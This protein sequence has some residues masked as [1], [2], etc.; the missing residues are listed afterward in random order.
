MFYYN[1]N[2]IMLR[3]AF[4]TLGC[5]SNLFDT[6]SMKTKFKEKGYKVVN[7][8]EEVADIYIVNTCTVTKSGDRSSRKA[9]YRLRRRNPKAIIVATG[10]YAQ[11]SPEELMNIEGVDIVVGNTHK[12]A[13]LNIVE[14][15]M[16]RR[17]KKVYVGNIFKVG[18]VEL[19]NPVVYFENSRPF[20]KVQ[21]GCNK[22]CTFCVIPF[23]RG[24]VRSVDKDKVVDTVKRLAY[25]GFEEVVLSGT[26]LSQYGW[27]KG[28]T[29]YELL[30]E[31]VKI[32]NIKLIRLSSLH[33]KEL[34][35]DTLNLLKEEE[36]IAPHFHLSL[37]SAS[38]RILNIMER[39]YTL[40]EY[41]KTAEELLKK[42]NTAIGTDIIVGF[43][44]ESED[45]FEKTR[46]FL[47]EFPFAYIHIFPYSDRPFA[48]A[49]KFKEKVKESVKRERVEIL[50]TID[51]LK[52]KHFKNMFLG[53]TLRATT[54]GNEKVL[55][56]NYL[57]L[58]GYNFGSKGKV[59][60]VCVR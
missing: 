20:V 28:Y 12:D 14:E 59:V 46:R 45:D 39:G 5:R 22:F 56:E 42:P 50:K 15:Y 3:V 44:T 52:R 31:L 9:I 48:K 54:L 33:V 49:S 6:F 18:E 11:I 43:P 1:H 19:F 36:K 17:E 10:C 21:E 41:V 4:E 7:S 25:S 34:D 13:I 26:Q 35:K 32:E 27:D 29:L 40:S 58:E 8:E 60:R 53:K 47:E 24:K 23:A 30:K 55:T 51:D 57:Y 2:N 16:E 38:D 37:Q